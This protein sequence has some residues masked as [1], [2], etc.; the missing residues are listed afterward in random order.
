MICRVYGTESCSQCHGVRHYLDSEG[1]EYEYLDVFKD[2]DAMDEIEGL[3]AK[4]VPVIRYGDETIIGFNV[5]KLKGVL[6][7]GNA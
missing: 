4:T 5:K 3:G 6:A 1:V 2:K 7:N